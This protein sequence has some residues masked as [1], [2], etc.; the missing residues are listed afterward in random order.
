MFRKS[1][2]DIPDLKLPVVF[3]YQKLVIL[4]H[5]YRC[6]H[7][8]VQCVTKLLRKNDYKTLSLRKC[9]TWKHNLVL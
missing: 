1:L 3:M 9:E 6:V 5:T 2:F 7:V 4:V 8:H